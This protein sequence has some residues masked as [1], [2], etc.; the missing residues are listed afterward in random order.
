[1]GSPIGA[2]RTSKFGSW[3]TFISWGKSVKTVRE[4]S[5]HLAG[6]IPICMQ[7]IEDGAGHPYLPE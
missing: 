4:N 7:E 2:P 3:D 1:M 6:L 5:S